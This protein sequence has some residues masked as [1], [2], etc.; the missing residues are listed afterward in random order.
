MGRQ[1]VRT[2]GEY[3]QLYLDTRLKQILQTSANAKGVSLN[4]LITSELA[5][6]YQDKVEE[7]AKRVEMP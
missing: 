3:F 5:F 1:R 4:T 7:T 2:G 6:L